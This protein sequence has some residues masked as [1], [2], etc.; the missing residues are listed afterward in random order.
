MLEEASEETMKMVEEGQR[1]LKRHADD[2]DGSLASG[3]GS[4]GR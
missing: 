2:E 1:D 3:V 4:V